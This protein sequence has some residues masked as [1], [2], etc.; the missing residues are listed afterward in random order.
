MTLGTVFF[1]I[2]LMFIVLFRNIKLALITLIPNVFSAGVVLA[3]MGI[4]TIPLDLMTIT[5]AAIS[6]GIA[7]DNSIHFVATVPGRIYVE[8]K[9]R[10]IDRYPP[11]TTLARRCSTLL[12]VIT[13]GFLIMVFSNFVP[14]MYFR[15]PYR[16]RH[17]NRFNCK[18]DYA[19]NVVGP[20][21]T[22][23]HFRSRT[24]I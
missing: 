18:P 22:P 8:S 24:I 12:L 19:A 9:L 17:G 23:E 4:F 14:T 1:V 11:P 5:I 6:V 7:V 16:D 15:H 3:L 13:A 21:Q 20:L 2:M 10:R